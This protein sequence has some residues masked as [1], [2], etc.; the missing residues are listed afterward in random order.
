MAYARNDGLT[1]DV[2]VIQTGAARKIWCFCG[3]IKKLM[4][5]ADAI[6]HLEAHR[7][8]GEKVPQRAFDRL[9]AEMRKRRSQKG[10][11]LT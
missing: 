11:I 4:C 2:Y 8:R 5:R 10:V 7:R 6:R 3:R 9:R 1:S